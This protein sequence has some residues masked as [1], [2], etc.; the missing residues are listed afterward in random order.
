MLGPEHAA[1]H[2]A[3]LGAERRWARL[4]HQPHADNPREALSS[5]GATLAAAGPPSEVGA[6]T[7]APFALSTFAIHTAVLP[8]GQLLIWGRPPLPG[9][10]A[11]RPPTA[12]VPPM[13]A[14]YCFPSR[15]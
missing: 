11:P 1:E 15:T 14:T 10:G 4:G 2:D 6:W 13:S 3:V 12:P 9:G 8:T 5:R 7:Q